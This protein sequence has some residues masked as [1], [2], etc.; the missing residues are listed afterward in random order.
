MS[1]VEGMVREDAPAA[2]NARAPRTEGVDPSLFLPNHKGERY[3]TVLQGINDHLRP[4]SYLEVGIRAGHSLAFAHC[5]SIGIDPRFTLTV[6]AHGKKPALHLFEE[7]SDKFFKER[8]AR[9]ILGV[10][11]VDFLFLDGAH[12]SDFLLRDI[13]GA[14]KVAGPDSIIALHDCMPIDIAM[15]LSRQERAVSPYPVVYQH[16]W[17]GDVWRLVPILKKYRPEIR[18]YCMDAHPTGLVLMTGLDPSSTVLSDNYDAI[19]AEMNGMN[20]A[21][22]GLRE[23]LASLPPLPTADFLGRENLLRHFKVW[24]GPGPEG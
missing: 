6:D 7:K 12:L 10:D 17:A 2:T 4:R 24:G 18:L 14:E 16:Y 3:Y 8:D 23:H 9:E 20:L 13:I 21:K 22:I 15:T 5:A 11:V 19:V 1:D